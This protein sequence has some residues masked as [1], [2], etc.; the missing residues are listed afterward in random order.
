MTTAGKQKKMECKNRIA[1]LK[2]AVMGNGGNPVS[3]STV[4]ARWHNFHLFLENKDLPSLEVI[5]SFVNEFTDGAGDYYSMPR[6]EM[7]RVS[8]KIIVRINEV[9]D[10]N[11]FRF[12][13][14]DFRGVI[15]RM[16]TGLEKAYDENSDKAFN[17]PEGSYLLIINR[18]LR[19][20]YEYR[21]KKLI[22]SGKITV[23]EGV[24]LAGE[25][26]ER[27]YGG[28][29]WVELPPKIFHTTTNL[30]GILETGLS[31]RRERNVARGVGLGGGE[32]D[33]ICLTDNEEYA[34]NLERSLHEMYL[35]ASGKLTVRKMVELARQGAGKVGRSWEAE[36]A[37]MAKA[38]LGTDDL[39]EII[40]ITEGR[41]PKSDDLLGPKRPYTPEEIEDITV[42]MAKAYMAARQEAGGFENPLFSFNDW[43]GFKQLDPKQFRTLC[44][45]PKPGARGYYLG[46]AEGEWRIVGGDAVEIENAV[47]FYDPKDID[48][49]VGI[50]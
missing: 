46:P 19:R 20:E 5:R 35:V 27:P 1:K 6:E 12:T 7:H 8:E 15:D 28:A 39:E 3:G 10:T 18:S 41:T 40:N 16:L 26:V 23:E 33:A 34:K 9:L 17:S 32:D 45:K 43:D 30:K 24:R 38:V 49:I 36:L 50:D 42:Q 4:C 31:S 37:K 14:N 25:N 47:A 29:R 2:N 13:L 21:V 48:S 11:D 44:L 22:S